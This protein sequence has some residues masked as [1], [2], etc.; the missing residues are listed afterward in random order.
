MWKQSLLRIKAGVKVGGLI[1]KVNGREVESSAQVRNEIGLLRV[2]S[3]VEIE[4]LRDGKKRQ[5]KASVGKQLK[6]TVS[7]KSLSDKLAGAK[8]SEASEDP[9]RGTA[10]GIEVVDADGR[11][12]ASGIRKGDIIISVNKKRGEERC[13]ICELPSR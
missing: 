7:G 5:L 2:G 9:S 6:Q 8:L 3:Q 1:V 11:A 13:G 4:V 10:A 12:A